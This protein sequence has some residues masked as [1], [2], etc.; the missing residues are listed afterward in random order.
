MPEDPFKDFKR[1]DRSL[2]IHGRP[3][4]DKYWAY[5]KDRLNPAIKVQDCL[6]FW[7][8]DFCN[9]GLEAFGDKYTQAVDL[10]TYSYEYL[11]NL[12]YICKN[13]PPQNRC[14]GVGINHH[15]AVAKIPLGE[16]EDMLLKAVAEG[17]NVQELRDYIDRAF[18]TKRRKPIH[19][20]WN[21]FY[22]GYILDHT[23]ASGATYEK[24]MKAS[25][26][27]GQKSR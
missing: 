12:C 26:E 15:Y 6:P 11:R 22:V 18:P 19:S 10:S 1:T 3:D 5:Y 9:Y 14:E 4:F 8:G 17:W 21:D 23:E 7:V 16:Q 24:H 2:T 13:V 25:F 27:A 20:D